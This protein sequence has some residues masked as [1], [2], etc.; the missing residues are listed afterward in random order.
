[1]VSQDNLKVNLTLRETI[2]DIFNLS[3]RWKW[4]VT[5]NLQL[6]FATAKIAPPAHR[7]CS[8]VTLDPTV[9]YVPVQMLLKQN[10]TIKNLVLR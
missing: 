4:R 9:P 1:M 6:L 5:F 8:W 3:A 7:I 10:W 2:Q